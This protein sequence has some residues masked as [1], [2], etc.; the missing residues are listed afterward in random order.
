MDGVEAAELTTAT[1][2]AGC[3]DLAN[4]GTR[5]KGM[6]M[7]GRFILQ[8]EPARQVDRFNIRVEEKGGTRIILSGSV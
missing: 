8:E 4:E 5:V 7:D 3:H 2:Q 1:V 6:K